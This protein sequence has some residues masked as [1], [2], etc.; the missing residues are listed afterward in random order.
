MRIKGEHD[1]VKKGHRDLENTRKYLLSK[2]RKI[3]IRSHKELDTYR[4][5]FNSAMEIFELTKK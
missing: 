3:K 4:L 1:G 2:R 5:A